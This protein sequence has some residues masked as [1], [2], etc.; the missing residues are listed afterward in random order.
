MRRSTRAQI[1]FL[2]LVVAFPV[3][4]LFSGTSTRAADLTRPASLQ[5]TVLDDTGKPLSGAA[6]SVE[7]LNGEQHVN[8]PPLLATTDADGIVTFTRSADAKTA[9][10]DAVAPTLAT[11]Q[12]VLS[13]KKD[14]RLP[15]TQMLTLFPGAQAE[16]KVTLDTKSTT[17]IR[18]PGPTGDPVPGARPSIFAVDSH[19]GGEQLSE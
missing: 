14:G 18:R 11:W 19:T 13:I 1:A 2:L 15:Q 6:V 7:R 16:K 17:I 3:V 4:S 5:V 10:G 12:E 8:I 9:N